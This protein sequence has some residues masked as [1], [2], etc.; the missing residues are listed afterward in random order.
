MNVA[1]RKAFE[2]F[3]NV[4]PARSIPGVQT[5]YNDIDLILVRENIEDTYAGVE[6]WQTPDVAESLG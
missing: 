4:R 5:R 3:A 1:I 6:Y 2:L